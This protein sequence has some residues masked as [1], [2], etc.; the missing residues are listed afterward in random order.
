MDK[1]TLR[2]ILHYSGK[3]RGKML[4]SVLSS[5]ISVACGF[6]PY[7]SV[8]QSFTGVGGCHVLVC[9]L[10]SRLYREGFIL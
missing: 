7:I 8:Y 3:C 10:F 5:I 6:T 2:F 1:E 4:L 9:D